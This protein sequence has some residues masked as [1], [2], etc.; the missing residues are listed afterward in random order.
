MNHKDFINYLKYLSECRINIDY[1]DD[2]NDL[3]KFQK[4][5]L[6]WVYDNTEYYD[7][8]SKI[9]WFIWYLTINSEIK[10]GDDRNTIFFILFDYL[11][12]YPDLYREIINDDF[13]VIEISNIIYKLLSKYQRPFLLNN[14][15]IT[16][17]SMFLE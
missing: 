16:N 11:I 14:Y 7:Y 1:K 17:I 5:L 9:A 3:T 15:D 13:T 12:D 8:H 4:D 2:D 6:K 10:P